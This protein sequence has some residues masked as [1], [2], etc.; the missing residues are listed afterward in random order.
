MIGTDKTQ[1]K[2]NYNVTTNEITHQLIFNGKGPAASSKRQKIHGL[3]NETKTN[4]TFSTPFTT[5]TVKKA[6]EVMN[7]AKAAVVYSI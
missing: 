4:C 1:A 5:Q 3:L 6:I 2:R 7:C